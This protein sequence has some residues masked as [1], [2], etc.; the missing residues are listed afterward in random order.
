[1]YRGFGRPVFLPLHESRCISRARLTGNP[2]HSSIGKGKDLALHVLCIILQAL[3]MD[4]ACHAHQLQA[5]SRLNPRKPVLFEACLSCFA[6][7][8]H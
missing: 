8:V 3:L 5:I 4:L 6:Y 7:Q 1:M 2:G